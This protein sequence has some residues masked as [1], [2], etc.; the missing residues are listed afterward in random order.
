MPG[1]VFQHS[2]NSLIPQIP[3]QTGKAQSLSEDEW[4]QSLFAFANKSPL[5]S[6][7]C[8]PMSDRKLTKKEEG[9]CPKMQAGRGLRAAQ[10]FAV[11]PAHPAF[12]GRRR[13]PA[14]VRTEAQTVPQ[15]LQM[16]ATESRERSS[17]GV[18][19]QL[20]DPAHQYGAPYPYGAQ[21]RAALLSA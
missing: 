3:V 15:A 16:A 11:M 9:N 18:W 8:R 6:Q 7:H 4:C 14:A 1:I 17:G 13:T 19:I 5:L 12:A 10:L 21:K 2:G 20:P